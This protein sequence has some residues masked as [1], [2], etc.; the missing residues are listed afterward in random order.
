MIELQSV[1][2]WEPALYLFLG[3]LGAGTFVVSAIIFLLEKVHRKT[4]AICMWTA[5]ACL[6]VGLGLLL[7]DVEKPFAALAMWQS[8]SNVGASWM[9]IGAWI[10]FCAVIVF[11]ACACFVT[12]K[13]T[14]KVAI[15]KRKTW[16]NVLAVIGILLGLGVAA[17]TG[18]LLKSA[19]GVP[20]WNTGILPLLFTVSAMDTG[21]AL[22]AIIFA[23]FEAEAAKVTRRNLEVG[24]VVLILVEVAVLVWFLK[25]MQTGGN[26]GAWDS[27]NAG[28]AATAMAG[29]DAVLH[30]S[31]SFA[32]WALVVVLGLA[33]PFLVAVY[34]IATAKKEEAGKSGRAIAIA[35][36]A[37]ALIGGCA[38]RF[39]V[40]LAGAHADIVVQS[41]ANIL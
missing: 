30:G 18:I 37:C 4:C 23:I 16:A 33:V 25:T 38:L 7:M 8:F 13:I 36:A 3:G 41:I 19:P 21:V 17:Y 32:F 11:A 15:E 28:Y 5:A 20:F 6:C 40:L 31:L 9:A 29:A 2:G 27:F 34:E 12:D 10:L 14:G 26:A 24:A 1:W 35:G 22:V 39:V